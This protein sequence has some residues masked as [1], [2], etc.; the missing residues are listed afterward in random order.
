MLISIT[1][2]DETL[3]ALDVISLRV[4]KELKHSPALL[5]SI[6][7]PRRGRGQL[8]RKGCPPRTSGSRCRRR[9]YHSTRSKSGHHRRRPY[10]MTIREVRL[11]RDHLKKSYLFVMEPVEDFIN[12]ILRVESLLKSQILFY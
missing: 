5:L 6:S 1:D 3:Q 4:K 12:F 11:F 10:R 7:E 9:H 2:R 8:K